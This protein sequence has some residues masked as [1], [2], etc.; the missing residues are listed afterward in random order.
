MT[1]F[2]YFCLDGLGMLALALFGRHWPHKCALSTYFPFGIWR[3]E[4]TKRSRLSMS[5][6]QE[7]KK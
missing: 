5:K 3:D 4:P 7:E 1:A 6:L 2:S